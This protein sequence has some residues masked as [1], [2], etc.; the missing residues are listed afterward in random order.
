ME[1]RK[2]VL[3]FA[4]IISLL[5]C[6]TVSAGEKHWAFDEMEGFKQSTAPIVNNISTC[7][8]INEE[9]WQRLHS[10]VLDKDKLD[11]PVKAQNWA[12]LLKMTLNLPENITD[13]L[14]KMYVYGL[15]EEQTINRENAVG[16]LVKLLTLDYI[17]GSTTVE[18]LE[19]S[20]KLT[21]LSRISDKQSVLVRIAYREGI[22][23]GT[24]KD[25][26]R[27]KDALTN[28]EA[29]SMLHRVIKRYGIRCK[30]VVALRHSQWLR[31]ETKGYFKNIRGNGE[32]L[33]IVEDILFGSGDLSDGTSLNKPVAIKN[34]D[35][36]LT[37]SLNLKDT[38]F[39]K[40]MLEGYTYGLSEKGFISR[41][42]AVAGT[43]KL[44]HAAGLLEGRD[45]SQDEK[46]TTASRFS[47]YQEAFD[48][49]KLSIAY[50]EGLITGYGDNT[51][52]PEQ[53]LSNAEAVALIARVS[54]R[55]SLN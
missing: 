46:E 42:R 27:P 37:A 33:G 55:Y 29:V 11:E 2:F 45:A 31:D 51:F 15:T 16:G 53:L 1:A 34:W 44:L 41:S 6:S 49:S 18:E 9:E 38:K 47:D 50:S 13:Q 3:S 40:N 14:L 21:D 7:N 52:R 17:S 8:I 19:G 25:K 43:V 48:K 12:V 54:G 28:G 26:F 30:L 20:K 32:L 35:N 4:L 24:V 36:L 10:Q 23:D 5:V 22:L 39:D